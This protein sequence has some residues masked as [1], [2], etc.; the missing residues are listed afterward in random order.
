MAGFTL[1]ELGVQTEPKGFTFEE[2]SVPQVAPQTTLPEVG[3]YT[4]D[5]M[6]ENDQMFS[7]IQRYMSDR[8]G[9]LSIEGDDRTTIVDKFLNNRRGVAAGNSVRAL[10]EIDYINDI[11]DDTTKTANAAAAAALYENMAGLF[12]KETSFAERAE[13]VMDFTRTAIADPINL[14]GGFIGKAVGQGALRVGSN[15]IKKEALKKMSKE[16]AKKGA[17]KESVKKAGK[18]A[19]KV[20]AREAG[21]ATTKEVAEYT[22]RVMSSK[23]FKR[24]A[25]KGALAEIGTTVAIDAA[26]GAGTEYLYQ[27]GLIKLGV[28]EDFDKYSMGFAALGATLIGGVQAGRVLLR[29]STDT[30]VPTLTV[31]EP[32]ADDVMI[33]LAESIR[34][35]SEALVVRSGSWERKVEGGIELK[36]LDS[37]FFVDLLLGHVDDDGNVVL[38]GLSQI[39]QEKGL[40]WSKRFE[41][42]K[43]AN[44]MA[45]VIK[46]SGPEQITD[47]IKAFEEATGNKLKNASE[48]TVDEFAD[49]FALKINHSARILNALSQGSKRN[50]ISPEDMTVQ[51][52]IQDA[53]DA[54]Y[55]PKKDDGKVGIPEL[56]P[57]YIRNN[58]NRVIRLLVSNPSTSALNMIG[59]GANAGIGMMSDMALATVHAGVGTMANLIGMKKQG[60]KSY[61]IANTLMESNASRVMRLFDP[62]MTYAAFESA[63][64]RNSDALEKLSNTLPGGIENTTRLITDSKISPEMQMLGLT[65]DQGIDIIQTISFVKAQDRFTKSQEFIFQ[66]DKALRTRYNKSWNE[67]YNS[68]DAA[69]IIASKEYRD[70]EATVVEKTLESIFSKSYKGTDTLGQLAG[71][72]EDA[73]NI[74][75]VGMLV[76]FGRFF[77]ATVDWGMQASGVSIVGKSLGYYGDK[78]WGEIGSKAAVSWALASTMVETERE[79]RKKGIG[80]FQTVDPLTGEVIT[81]QYD[82]PISAFKAAARI[83]SYYMDGEEPPKE[84]IA[85]AAR[86]FTLEGVLRNLNRTQEDVASMVYYMFQADMKEAWR[87]FGKSMGGVAVQP[88]AGATRFIEPLNIAA[89]VV[90]GEDARPIDRY[91][92]NKIVNDM[93]KY[94]DNL[95]PLFTGESKAEL[96]DSDTLQTAAAG[97]ADIT[98]TKP[99]GIRTLRLTDTQRIMNMMGL[100]EFDI[101]AARKIRQTVPEAAN[102]YNGILFDII[103]AESSALMA[104][105][106]FR[107]QST[108][109]QRT[110]WEKEVLPKAKS[111]AKTFLAMQF[112]GPLDT[113]DLQ[114]ELSQKYTRDDLND[115]IEEL[116]L[117]DGGDF[118]DMTR[119]QLFLIKSYLE[120]VDSLNLLRMPSEVGATRYLSR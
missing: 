36:D 28:R 70:I 115:A 54:G 105:E 37:E 108:K 110:Y 13:G 81:Q 117:E 51:D 12:S 119:G 64:V 33:D 11:S 4:Q 3:T 24:L 114:Y 93:F 80:L 50:G 10:S 57:E 96:F 118:G 41:D 29:G 87:A 40:S 86:D 21:K 35:Y 27:S 71:I 34:K 25:T 2:L 68:P 17:T 42:D 14:V 32:K 111:L 62:D 52:L 92:G 20:A 59:Y 90:Q 7:I 103:E 82:Y 75:G 53:I 74:P 98:S 23:G 16:G 31:K 15:Q 109:E 107:N 44:W 22:S 67:F 61:K 66:M 94:V 43:Y 38:K 95:I 101:N 73:R 65:T 112:S 99:M 55:L 89:G 1:D 79:N 39:A 58:Q 106:R 47:F 69:Q 77:N 19:I 60:A 46:Q 45:D 113:I 18:E 9:P 100:P 120:T 102:E 49:T 116:N 83:A 8:Y 88:I 91:Q 72:I 76:P 30:A 48:L 97:E 78:S 85:Q 104:T 56:F 5:D 26:V 63:L 84:L 6:V